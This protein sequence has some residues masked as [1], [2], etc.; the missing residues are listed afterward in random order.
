MD[1]GDSN[2]SDSDI[3]DSDVRGSDKVAQTRVIR[4]WV[5]RMWVIRTSVTRMCVTRMWMTRSRSQSGSN[6]ATRICLSDSDWGDSDLTG[7]YLAGR[8]ACARLR[9]PEAGR[10][11]AAARFHGCHNWS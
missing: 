3:R 7:P 8:H 9:R 4:M 1:A 10:L 6:R 2:I 5:T 11:L